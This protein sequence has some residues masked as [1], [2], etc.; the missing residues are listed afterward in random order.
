METNARPQD[1]LQ[2]K[3]EALIAAAEEYWQEY[4][5]TLY[6]SAVVWLKADNGQFVLFTRGEYLPRIMEVV[7]YINASE[8]PLETLFAL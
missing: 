8:P 1:E 7:D 2:R 4:Q 6:P 5:R 3:A